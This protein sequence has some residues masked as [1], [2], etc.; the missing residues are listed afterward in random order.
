MDTVQVSTLPNGVRIVSERIPHSGTVALGVWVAAGGR[1]ETEQNN[2]ISHFLEHMAFKGTATRTARQIAEEVERVGGHLNA[3]TA[4]EETAYYA[5]VLKE[6]LA[7]GIDI[8]ADILIHPTFCPEELERERGV[9]LQEIGR[10]QDSPDD[11]VFDHLQNVA[12]PDQPMGRSI[13]GPQSI[14]SSLSAEDLRAYRDHLYRGPHLIFSAA[15]NV[16]Q[17]ALVRLVSQAFEN[18]PSTPS[19][20]ILAPAR[21]IGGVLADTRPL[22]Q[23]H[24]TLGVES[25]AFEDPDYYVATLFSSILGRGMSSRLFQEVREKRGLAYSIY[26]FGAVYKDSGLMGIYAGTSADKCSELVKVARDECL[27]MADG[28]TKEE[29][30]RA[31]AQ[32]KSALMMAAESTP[33]V[34][35]QNADHMLVYGRPISREEMIEK[36]EAVTDAQIAHFTERLFHGKAITLA[37]VGPVDKDAAQ[38]LAYSFQH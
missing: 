35:E 9:I 29:M 19:D 16:H 14:V 38:D 36:A 4:R 15:G 30:R 1:C 23:V 3:Y 24:I 21:Y 34:C 13:L 7:V 26:S 6:D 10:T 11:I 2:G 37:I 8:I 17:D 18:L 28:I 22:E 33:A 12:Y 27:K 31:R 25:V 20:H 32:F 5:H